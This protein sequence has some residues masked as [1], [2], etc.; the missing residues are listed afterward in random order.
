MQVEGPEYVQMRVGWHKLAHPL[1]GKDSM[2]V[3][4][5]FPKY[6]FPTLFHFPLFDF[7]LK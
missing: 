7:K 6:C 3:S 2:K 1:F 4:F 5:L